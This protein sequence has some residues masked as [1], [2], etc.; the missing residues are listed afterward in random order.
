MRPTDL[1]AAATD[2]HYGADRAETD[3]RGFAPVSPDDPAVHRIPR[4]RSRP[5]PDPWEPGSDPGDPDALAR[6]RPA[7]A[8]AAGTDRAAPRAGAP[9]GRAA[10]RRRRATGR[11]PE[12]AATDRRAPTAHRDAA[13]GNPPDGGDVRD[14]RQRPD[15]GDRL[16]AA[17]PLDAREPLD[18]PG[19]RTGRRPAADRTRTDRTTSDR[20]R[21]ATDRTGTGRTRTARAADSRPRRPARPRTSDQGGDP[22]AA[23]PATATATAVAPD[24]TAW[25]APGPRVRTV[26][27]PVAVGTLVAV[28]LGAWARQHDPTGVA[29]N[30]AGFSSGAAVKTWLASMALLLGLAQGWTAMV[31]HGRFGP[32]PTPLVRGVHRWS[33]RLAVL[34]TV[35]VAVQCLYA[36]GWSGATPR[37]LL[38]SLLGCAFYGAFVTKM[39]LLHRRG[40]PGW[41]VAVCGGLVLAV[42]TGIWLTSALWFFGTHGLS[43]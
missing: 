36:L 11:P 37:T 41:A 34:I 38:H 43:F 28:A 8:R 2:D 16:H 1:Y 18:R 17:D 26:L 33:G 42:L 14:G 32:G 7:R 19:P 15:V 29:V 23:D 30:L 6:R 4:Q 9:D 35:P 12:P 3:P 21:T 40:V 20:T 27:V 39:L 5:E 31:L 24:G 13:A 22:A 10:A 25:L